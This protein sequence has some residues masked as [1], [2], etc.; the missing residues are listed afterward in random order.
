MMSFQGKF[1]SFEIAD[2]ALQI[3]PDNPQPMMTYTIR[4]LTCQGSIKLGS[5]KGE[6]AGQGFWRPLV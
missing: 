2:M 4:I 1:D 3:I 5:T 6:G